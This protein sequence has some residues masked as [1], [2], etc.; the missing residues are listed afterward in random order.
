MSTTSATSSSTAA[1][2][3]QTLDQADFLKLLVTQMTSQDPLN[4]QSDT[5]FAAQLAQFSALQQSQTMAT[6]M[7]QMQ[8]NGLIGQT[9]NVT[10]AT[11]T[12]Q[13]VTGV[14]SAVQIAAGVPQIQVNGELYD[15]SDI[16]S[17]TPTQTTTTTSTP[18]PNP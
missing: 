6:D 13:Q 5:A 9:V 8:A 18:T 7:Q 15:M 12:S 17:I 3:G 14:V 11:N 4:P 10:S 16:T 2:A 1:A